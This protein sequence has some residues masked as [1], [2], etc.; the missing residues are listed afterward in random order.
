MKN[1][2]VKAANCDVLILYINLLHIRQRSLQ[3]ISQV[4]VMFK[5]LS[6][7]IPPQE[8]NNKSI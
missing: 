5:T 4:F 7:H 6:L 8:K 3:L 1:S 2:A